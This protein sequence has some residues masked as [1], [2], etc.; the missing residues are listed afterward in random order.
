[1]II[2]VQSKF[3]KILN[4]YDGNFNINLRHLEG[5]LKAYPCQKLRLPVTDNIFII[6]TPLFIVKMSF[7][8]SV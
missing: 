3:L 1:M 5:K 6:K 4:A 8:N 7:K 2:L